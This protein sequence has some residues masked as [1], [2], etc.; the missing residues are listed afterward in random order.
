MLPWIGGG[1][2]LGMSRRPLRHVALVGFAG[3]VLAGVINLVF[4]A[5]NW[6]Q[7]IFSY[8]M[9]G[10]I[11]AG[12]AMSFAAGSLLAIIGYPLGLLISRLR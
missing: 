3:V 12:A 6:R 7:V 9:L 5:L 1:V 2:A 4:M 10:R 11:V 8:D